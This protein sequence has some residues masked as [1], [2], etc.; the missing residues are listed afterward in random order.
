MS[1]IEPAR[2]WWQEFTGEE[3]TP[4]DGDTPAWAMSL[5]LHVVVLLS[6]ALIGLPAIA[7][8]QSSITILAPTQVV[9]ED[10]LVA[11]EMT[12]AVEEQAS[13]SSDAENLEVSTAVAS[14]LSDDPVVTVDV[15]EALNA[16]RAISPI[17]LPPSGA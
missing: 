9:E 15:A 17:D 10:V 2:R 4:L 6:L 3:E 1:W 7:P 14:V 12:V 11:P 13:A 5:V 16:E 8:R